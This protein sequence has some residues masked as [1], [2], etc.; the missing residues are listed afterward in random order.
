[1]AGVKGGEYTLTAS[2]YR[3]RDED[4]VPRRYK[5]GDKITL[6]AEQ[7]NRLLLAGAIAKPS[8]DAGQAAE[9]RPGSDPAIA[10]PAVTL[11]AADPAS[12]STFGALAANSGLGPLDAT[13]GALADDQLEGG[14]SSEDGPPP[15]SATA[16]RWR[17][18]AVSSGKVT[19]DEAGEL[20]KSELQAL[21]DD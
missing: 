9:A 3:E 10:P 18:W 14:S 19:E 4:G 5:R 17:S 1:M 8:S 7:A 13:G 2:I 21:A 16:D 6:N 20:T 11:D 12:A 15:K